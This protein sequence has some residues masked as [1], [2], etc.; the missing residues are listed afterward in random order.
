MRVAA[1]VGHDEAEFSGATTEPAEGGGAVET[2]FDRNVGG[3]ANVDGAAGVVL[4]ETRGGDEAEDVRQGAT[5]GEVSSDD[6]ILARDAAEA[7]E[8]DQRDAVG[9]SCCV[10]ALPS[11]GGAAGQTDRFVV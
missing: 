4:A 1:R 2:V 10:H 3:I 9:G 6:A 7:R 11:G 5:F 8:R